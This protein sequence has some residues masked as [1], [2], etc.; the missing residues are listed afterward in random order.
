MNSSRFCTAEFRVSKTFM[1]FAAETIEAAC[2]GE[3][4]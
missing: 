2:P 4:K 3:C 1:N